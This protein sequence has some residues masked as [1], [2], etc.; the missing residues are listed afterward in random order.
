MLLSAAFFMRID[1]IICLVKP[2]KSNR[3]NSVN[4]RAKARN[5]SI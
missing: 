1:K 2:M 5:D 3:E 4:M